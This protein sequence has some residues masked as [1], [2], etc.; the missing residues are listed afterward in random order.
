MEERNEPSFRPDAGRS[1]L[2]A[3]ATAEDGAR[4][5][6]ETIGKGEPLLLVMGQGADHPGRIGALVLGCT[7]PG[8]AH[9]VRREPEMDDAFRNRA[10]DD[11]AVSKLLDALISPGWLASHPEF[12]A[13]MAERAENPIPPH[14]QKFTSWRAK[15]MTLGIFSPPSPRRRWS[16]TAARIG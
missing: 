9:G 16:S 11:N 1:H 15:G 10:S 8:N 14:A 5:Y 3:F 2:L 4:L 7:T 13:R 12:L 6:Y